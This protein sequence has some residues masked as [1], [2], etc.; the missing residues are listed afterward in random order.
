MLCFSYKKELLKQYL[1]FSIIFILIAVSALV[2]SN[3]AW[4]IV[5]P[6]VMALIYL[7]FYLFTKAYNYVIISNNKIKVN[8]LI[9]KEIQLNELVEVKYFAGELTLKSLKTTLVIKKDNMSKDSFYDL[10]SELIRLGVV[11][12]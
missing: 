9:S 11:W 1:Y 8:S 7:E 5:Y 3:S 12:N 6:I 10:K 2:T 4:N